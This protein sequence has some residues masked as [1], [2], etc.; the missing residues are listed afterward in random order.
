MAT[1]GVP[2]LGGLVSAE[3]HSKRPPKGG[4]PNVGNP[5]LFVNCHEILT[6]Y[7]LSSLSPR[8]RSAYISLRFGV[9]MWGQEPLAKF[10]NRNLT[11]FR[12]AFPMQSNPFQFMQSLGSEKTF[13]AVWTC[14]QRNIFDHEQ[15]FPFT[16]RF[17]YFVN[18]RAFFLTNITG[19]LS[20]AYVLY[21]TERARFFNHGFSRIN[22]D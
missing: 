16:E 4:T 6:G 8:Y 18:S 14:N 5:G 10:R 13:H 3:L 19:H 12:E 11:F 15:V 20:F 9:F 22:T 1:F 21:R 2:L 17:S 7:Q